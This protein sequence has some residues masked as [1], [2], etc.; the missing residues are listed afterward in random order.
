MGEFDVLMKAL[1]NAHREFYF[2]FE[3]LTDDDLWRRAHPNL[4]SVGELAGHVSYW[5]AMGVYSDDLADQIHSPLMDKRFDYYRNTVGQPVV[6]ELGVEAL[7]AEMKR[8]YELVRRRIL[9]ASPQL[10]DKNP[11]RPMFTW[12]GH[13]EY[14]AFHA[15]YHCGQ[16][17]SVRHI[18]GHTTTDN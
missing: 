16:A 8:I 6:L 5:W 17:Y 10:S 13:L 9:D 2:A 4:L 7:V 12:Q 14:Q 1:D 18:L 3:G 15:A 11:S